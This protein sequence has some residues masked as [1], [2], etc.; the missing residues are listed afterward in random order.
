MAKNTYIRIEGI[1]KLVKDLNRAG[2][3]MEHE[4]VAGVKAASRIVESDMERRA[5]NLPQAKG[6]LATKTDV[7]NTYHD[8]GKV[9]ALIGPAGKIEHSFWAE[10]G[11]HGHKKNTSRQYARPAVDKNKKK[12]REVITEAIWKA[13]ERVMK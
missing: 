12:I 4:L 11:V 2:D 1:E 5:R 7:I 6:K 3:S 8:E 13:F 10:V 9:S